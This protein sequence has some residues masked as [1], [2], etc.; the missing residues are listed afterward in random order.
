MLSSLLGLKDT[1]I[2]QRTTYNMSGRVV[3]D[4]QPFAFG[5]SLYIRYNTDANI[6][7]YL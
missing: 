4:I 1:H 7:K 2:I 5:S 3:T 6:V